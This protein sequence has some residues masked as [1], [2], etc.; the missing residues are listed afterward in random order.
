ML[1]RIKPHSLH[2]DNLVSGSGCQSVH[3]SDPLSGELE[4]VE[5]GFGAGQVGAGAFEVSCDPLEVAVEESIAVPIED[6]F[7]DGASAADGYYRP[8]E[9]HTF[10]TVESFVTDG[11]ELRNF[12]ELR[13]PRLGRA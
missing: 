3:N 6:E 5:D 9:Q 2:R 4:R 8:L 10:Y 13:L 1:E 11:L 7:V 12:V